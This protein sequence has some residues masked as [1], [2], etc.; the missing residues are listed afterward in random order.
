M[1]FDRLR[2]SKWFDTIYRVGIVIKG[3][4][5][6]VELVTGILL[7][8]SPQ[9][10]HR[11]LEHVADTAGQHPGTVFEIIEKTVVNLE[12]HL[13]GSVLFIIILFLISHGV[14]K[15]VLVYCLLKKIYRAYPYALAILVIMFFIQII[16]LFSDPGSIGIWLITVLNAAIIFLVWAEYQDLREEV[17]ASK[18]L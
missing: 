18:K 2:H 6:F 13:S 8:I 11:L 7:I 3:F 15:L 14:I 10:P 1:L 12:A 5:G 17:L 4:D 9:T 16:P